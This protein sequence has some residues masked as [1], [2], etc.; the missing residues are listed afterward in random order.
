[1][2]TAIIGLVE[3]RVTLFID[4]KSA[5]EFEDP[6]G[7]RDQALFMSPEVRTALRISSITRLEGNRV[8][9]EIDPTHV[10]EYEKGL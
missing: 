2:K 4:G 8:K 6:K 7:E 10:R 1:M 9:V 3:G 5:I